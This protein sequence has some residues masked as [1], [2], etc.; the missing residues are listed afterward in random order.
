MN[1]WSKS[2]GKDEKDYWTYSRMQLIV[3]IWR[4]ISITSPLTNVK[5]YFSDGTAACLLFLLWQ[6]CIIA[7]MLSELLKLK[8]DWSKNSPSGKKHI[9]KIT[10][11]VFNL[12]FEVF[13]IFPALSFQYSL[14]TPSPVETTTVNHGPYNFTYIQFYVFPLIAG[15]VRRIHKKLIKWEL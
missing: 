1:L 4:P 3:I 6:L 14:F 5:N 13:I 9:N 10:L 2:L 15:K 7:K 11:R 8:R 12:L